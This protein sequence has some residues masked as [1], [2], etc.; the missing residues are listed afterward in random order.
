MNKKIMILGTAGILLSGCAGMGPET[1]SAMHYT[2][3]GWTYT[4]VAD[5]NWAAAEK[6]LKAHVDAYP[7]DSFAKFNLGLVYAQMGR[8]EDAMG[9]F[10]D[11]SHQKLNRAVQVRMASG[12]YHIFDDLA[13]LA[14]MMIAELNSSVTVRDVESAALNTSAQ[15][16]IA[17]AEIKSV[18]PSRS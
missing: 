6:V 10:S 9:M 11:C 5:Q 3:Q 7:T 15:G 1:N 4:A 13:Q 12:D 18:Q 2:D 16:A 14:E 8:N 17:L